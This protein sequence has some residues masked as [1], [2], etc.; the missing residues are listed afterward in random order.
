[1]P[2]RKGIYLLDS[3][4]FMKIS[5]AIDTKVKPFYNWQRKHR[6]GSMNGNNILMTI[7]RNIVEEKKYPS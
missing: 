4:A 6:V 3:L 7:S 1:V 2:K 5:T